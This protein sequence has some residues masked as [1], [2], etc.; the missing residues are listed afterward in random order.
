MRE[1]PYVTHLRDLV[2]PSTVGTAIIPHWR[3]TTAYGFGLSAEGARSFVEVALRRE[4]SDFA[5]QH[6]RRRARA[7]AGDAAEVC[8]STPNERENEERGDLHLESAWLG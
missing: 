5:R 7:R 4:H 8:R 2:H 6:I 3:R 1:H